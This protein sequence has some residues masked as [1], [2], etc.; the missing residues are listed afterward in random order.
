[1]AQVETQEAHRTSLAEAVGLV[2]PPSTVRTFLIR[3]CHLSSV[4]AAAGVV[5]AAA[6][7]TAVLALTTAAAEIAKARGCKSIAIGDVRQA[8]E[9]SQALQATFPNLSFLNDSLLPT[10]TQNEHTLPRETLKEAARR[11]LRAEKAAARKATKTT[12]KS[13]ATLVMKTAKSG[14]ATKAA[15]TIK[16]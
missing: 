2:V 12:P 11:E 6:T 10:S 9:E 14:A 1:M 4:G 15:K 3:R 16:A 8:Y 7:Q 13:K 5:S